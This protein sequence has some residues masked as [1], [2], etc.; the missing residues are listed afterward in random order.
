MNKGKGCSVEKTKEKYNTSKI[1]V[2][3]PCYNGSAHIARAIRSVINQIYKNWRL[4]VVD[5]GSTDNSVEIIHGLKDPRIKVIQQENKGVSAARN[6]GIKAAR[7]EWV[8]F[9]DADDE[10]MPTY[11]QEIMGA[12]SKFPDVVAIFTDYIITPPGMAGLA[13][14][15]KSP[16]LIK[17]YFSFVLGHR[18]GMW[19]SCSVAKKSVL[20]QLG[21][22]PMGVTHGEDLDTWARLSWTGD[23]VCIPKALAIYNIDTPNSAMKIPLKNRIKI[24][25][26]IWITYQEW[27]ESNRIPQEKLHSTERYIAYQMFWHAIN[28]I[29]AGLKKEAA[30]I[31]KKVYLLETVSWRQRVLKALVLAPGRSGTYL[32]KTADAIRKTLNKFGANLKMKA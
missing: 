2:V 8:A 16:I 14:L 19:T 18:R 29:D 10:W 5:D 6:R 11:L 26:R 1:T 9:L 15:P 21:G 20:E 12:A 25:P 24:L 30:K 3:I 22:F 32:W 27:L 28:L 23:L 7:T 17:D 13:H 4:I 31:A